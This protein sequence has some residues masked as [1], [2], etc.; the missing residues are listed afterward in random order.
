MR[1]PHRFLPVGP[2][3]IKEIMSKLTS[4]TQFKF[5][6]EG[7][8]V[9]LRMTGGGRNNTAMCKEI[10]PNLPNGERDA[11]GI[12]AAVQRARGEFWPRATR[13]SVAGQGG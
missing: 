8:E 3:N 12:V 1:R 2:F 11:A 6:P 4:R 7:V 9:C 13:A 10:V 5:L